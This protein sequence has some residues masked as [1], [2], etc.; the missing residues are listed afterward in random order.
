MGVFSRMDIEK[1]TI[2][3]S[4]SKKFRTNM[5]NKAKINE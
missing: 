3:E 5:A 4:P 2:R 1:D